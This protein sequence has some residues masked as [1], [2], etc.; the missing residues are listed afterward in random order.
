M[1]GMPPPP[2]HARLATVR[3]LL[4]E[5]PLLLAVA[6]LGF[7]VSFQTISGLA[8]QQ[9]MP[10]WPVLYPILIDVGLLAAIVEAR[11]AIDDDRSDLAPRMLAWA[12]AA[13]TVYVNA[14]G[15]PAGDWLGLTL[16]VTAPALWIAF[17]ELTR[18]RK[19]RK[20]KAA[21]GDRIPLARWAFTPIAT[22]G[23][24]K[25]M[26]M[27]NVTSYPVAVAR[28]EARMLAMDLARAEAGRR[29]RKTIPALLRHHL[30]TG[31]L[32]EAVTRAADSAAYGS[33]PVMAE[34]VSIWVAEALTQA[35]KA[36]AEVRARRRV[37]ETSAAASQP[38]AQA[39][40]EQPQAKRQ[41]AR[42]QAIN[43]R[44]KAQRLLTDDPALPL[45]EVAR[46]SGISKATVERVKREMPVP[47]RVA[48]GHH[49]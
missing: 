7:A 38:A 48:G 19:V 44:L 24:R 9:H 46:R 25:R 16:H 4:R 43:G 10:G 17:L 26:V 39:P 5:N 14:H 31:T 32:P 1:S 28:E 11:K 3:G 33:M 40:S 2:K 37:I 35:S 8:Q 45:A 12:L 23:M 41:P 18:W 30:A 36:A 49:D 27:N 42:R 22:L 15:S 13:L 34:P 20:A 21:K 29:W 47:L 6:G